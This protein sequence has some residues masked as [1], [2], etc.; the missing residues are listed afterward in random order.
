MT[1]QV[2][3][4]VEGQGVGAPLPYGVV[5]PNMQEL[6]VA[7]PLQAG[8]FYRIRIYASDVTVGELNVQ[9]WPPD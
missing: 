8:A 1:W 7:E 6:V 4:R 3:A 5:P 9:Y 2:A